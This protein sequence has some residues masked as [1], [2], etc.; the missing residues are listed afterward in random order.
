[1]AR[2]RAFPR[3]RRLYTTTHWSLPAAWQ[4][5]VC[6]RRNLLITLV[7]GVCL[8]HRETVASLLRF[9]D[10]TNETESGRTDRRTTLANNAYLAA[11]TG[12][13]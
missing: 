2:N 7:A 10:M 12:K 8:Q 6:D 9:L 4:V 1:M 11:K 3:T 13:Q 5:L